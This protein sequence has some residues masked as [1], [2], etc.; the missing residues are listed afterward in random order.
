MIYFPTTFENVVTLKVNLLLRIKEIEQKKTFELS[1]L[2]SNGKNLICPADEANSFNTFGLIRSYPFQH[3]LYVHFYM[4]IILII[5]DILL[6][7]FQCEQIEAELTN[8]LNQRRAAL[9]ACLDTLLSYSA[10]VSQVCFK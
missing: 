6:F 10:I 4:S 3:D 5:V 2:K 9:R 8:V 1:I 7:F